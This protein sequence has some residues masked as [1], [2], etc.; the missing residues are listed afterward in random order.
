MPGILTRSALRK[1]WELTALLA[2]VGFG[3]SLGLW[4]MYEKLAND[5]TLRVGSR[6]DYKE[7]D[8]S[9]TPE[10]KAKRKEA[11]LRGAEIKKQWI[12]KAR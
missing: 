8:D 3:A 5:R 11:G 10:E 12:I 7:L 4:K 9:M 1:N 6:I 2:A